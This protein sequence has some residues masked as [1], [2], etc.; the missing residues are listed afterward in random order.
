LAAEGSSSPL[1]NEANICRLIE[2]VGLFADGKRGIRMRIWEETPKAFE[3]YS[4]PKPELAY[5][6]FRGK[7][8][9]QLSTL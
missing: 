6:S 2:A 8:R 3:E 7:V 1:F 4:S 9:K 5:K